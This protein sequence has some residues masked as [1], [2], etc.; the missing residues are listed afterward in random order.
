MRVSA[1]RLRLA[2]AVVAWL[3]QALMPVA[4]AAMM[5]LPQHPH[6]LVR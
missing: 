3:A 6:D 4:H 1:A 5:A 2:L